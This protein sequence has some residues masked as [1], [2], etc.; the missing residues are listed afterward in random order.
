MSG[1]ATSDFGAL[2]DGGSRSSRGSSGMDA[3][4]GGIV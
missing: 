2:R 1:F 4:H 3:F